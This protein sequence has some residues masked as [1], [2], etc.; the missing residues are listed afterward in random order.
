[1]RYTLPEFEPMDE[2]PADTRRWFNRE[3]RMWVVQL[4][5]AAGEQIGE[6]TYTG[7]GKAYAMRVER[8][9]RVEHGLAAQ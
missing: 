6:A 5:N 7:G 1:M 4:L 3:E 9:L 8:D 2:T